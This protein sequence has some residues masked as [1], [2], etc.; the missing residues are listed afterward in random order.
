MGLGIG[1]YQGPQGLSQIQHNMHHWSKD[2]YGGKNASVARSWHEYCA[3]E[4]FSR[5]ARS[6]LVTI[7]DLLSCFIQYHASVIKTVRESFKNETGTRCVAIALDT[8]GPEIRTGRMKD[9][10]EVSPKLN[11]SL[12]RIV[13]LI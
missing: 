6:E 7:N 13:V 9:D 1:C 3:Y 11:S 5:V 10:A 8:K 12:W 4:L 2:E